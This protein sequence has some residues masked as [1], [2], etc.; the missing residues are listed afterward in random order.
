MLVAEVLEKEARDESM[1][2]SGEEMK[3]VT[4]ADIS[5]EDCSSTLS[6]EVCPAYEWT[7][8]GVRSEGYEK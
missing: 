5:I 7:T 3:I 6:C 4:C 1:S 8:G 2:I